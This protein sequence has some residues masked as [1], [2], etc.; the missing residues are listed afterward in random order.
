MRNTVSPPADLIIFDWETIV[1]EASGDVVRYG[2][3]RLLVNTDVGL[4]GPHGFAML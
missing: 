2:P 3:N 4:K 1:D